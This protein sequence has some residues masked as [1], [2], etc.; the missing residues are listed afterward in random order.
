MLA[1]PKDTWLLIDM[2]AL[3]WG[4]ADPNFKCLPIIRYPRQLS[5]AFRL[6]NQW[7]IISLKTRKLR[8]LPLPRLLRIF[9]VKDLLDLQAEQGHKPPRF[10]KRQ[11]KAKHHFMQ[12]CHRS[13]KKSNFS[14]ASAQ[15]QEINHHQA[16][17]ISR[18]ILTTAFEFMPI[19]TPNRTLVPK[20]MFE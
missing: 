5:K 18:T 16:F 3:V 12:R 1:A 7:P 15:L 20:H 8:E 9:S 14:V 10:S 17:L 4:H 19:R 11:N 6:L 13:Q 2:V